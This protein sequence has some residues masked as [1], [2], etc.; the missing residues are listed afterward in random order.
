[1]HSDFILIGRH[2]IHAPSIAHYVE[3]DGYLTVISNYFA[4]LDVSRIEAT[5]EDMDKALERW[6]EQKGNAMYA[7]QDL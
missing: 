4:K 1:M 7:S 2:R 5:A 6:E 3:E